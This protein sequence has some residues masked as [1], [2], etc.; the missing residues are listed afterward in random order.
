VA[1]LVE[2]TLRASPVGSARFMGGHDRAIPYKWVSLNIGLARSC[3]P[4]K[5]ADPTG[6][7]RNDG[8][9]HMLVN[10]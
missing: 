8:L 9:A 4:I 5:R 7:A 2:H 10:V 3:P 1:H 6:L